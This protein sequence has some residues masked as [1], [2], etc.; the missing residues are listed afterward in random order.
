MARTIEVIKA[1]II[2]AKDAETNLSSLNSPS[3]TAIWN[4]W[5]YITA[6]CIYYLESLIDL[7]TVEIEAKISNGIVGTAGW[8]KARTL[9]FQYDI[10]TPQ[11][12]QVGT[13]YSI[14]YSTIDTTKQIITRCSVVQSGNKEVSIKVA[15]SVVPEVLTALEKASLVGYWNT[16]GFAGV[17]INIVNEVSDKLYLS[18]TIYYDGQYSEVIS[19]TVILSINNYLASLPFDGV[20]KLSAIEDAIQS[21]IGVKDITLIDVALR[22]DSTAFGSTTYMKQGGLFLVKSITPYSGYAIEETTGGY[23]FVDKLTFITE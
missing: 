12:L 7:F 21:T 23:T 10:T 8:I 18:G 5:A 3:Q 17:Q 20:I 16:L 6:F 4:L 14:N 9:Q 19:D 2:A 13:D 1:Q 15:K 11:L 22:A